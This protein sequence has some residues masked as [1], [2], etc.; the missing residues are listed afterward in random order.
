MLGI[1]LKNCQSTTHRSHGPSLQPLGIILK[2]CQSTTLHEP[3]LARVRL[4][5]ILK[6]CQSTTPAGSSL[7]TG[8][9][10]IILK[11]CQS[12]TRPRI[13]LILNDLP[14]KQRI[15]I[16]RAT[17]EVDCDLCFFSCQISKTPAGTRK[18]RADSVSAGAA[19]SPLPKN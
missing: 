16:E 19:L 8:G 10:G 13:S 12:T 7:A 11:N 9:L 15:K 2:N 14:A 5:I 6:N 4:G 17:C 18:I 3:L 1:I